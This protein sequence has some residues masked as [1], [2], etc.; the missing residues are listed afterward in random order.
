MGVSRLMLR[1]QRQFR[2]WRSFV[3]FVSFKISWSSSKEE[4]CE[5]NFIFEKKNTKI[6]KK[7]KKSWRKETKGKITKK[8]YFLFRRKG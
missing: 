5:K 3:K 7:E 4:K 1:W 8:S 6:E 2:L